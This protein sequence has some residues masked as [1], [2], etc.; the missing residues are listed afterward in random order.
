MGTKGDAIL[1]HVKRTLETEKPGSPVILDKLLLPLPPVNPLPY[2]E[3]EVSD[4]QWE[5]YR[6]RLAGIIS[7][8]VSG[9][10]VSNYLSSLVGQQGVVVGTAQERAWFDEVMYSPEA[11]MPAERSELRRRVAGVVEYLE[12]VLAKRWADPVGLLDEMRQ[13]AAEHHN[14]CTLG[15]AQI[16]LTMRMD[17]F[18]HRSD[19]ASGAEAAVDSMALF[20]ANLFKQ[21]AIAEAFIGGAHL[22]QDKEQIE[23]F[24]WQTIRFNELLG[25]G[26]PIKGTH[27]AYSSRGG[28]MSGDLFKVLEVLR[29]GDKLG[30]FV[31]DGQFNGVFV[32]G[33]YQRH[34][35]ALYT[36]E[37]S[38]DTTAQ[39]SF[40]RQKTRGVLQRIGL[41]RPST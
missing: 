35:R 37:L 2:P 36:G 23:T 4:L 11:R 24:L 31:A 1:E 34:L 25:L 27:F 33:K 16:E 21:N 41:L 39:K 10:A 15:L 3:M 40:Y 8:A 13:Y 17:A 7:K 29:D 12:Q 26:I 20:L 6:R 32:S 18:I 5:E 19:E 14:N 22:I 28:D 9:A 38:G 30:D